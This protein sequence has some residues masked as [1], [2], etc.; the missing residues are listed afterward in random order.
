MTFPAPTV[1]CD[2]SGQW[3]TG[4]TSL[5]GLFPC[6][7]LIVVDPRLVP[8][9]HPAEETFFSHVPVPIQ[10]NGADVSL[11]VL[12]LL[13]ELFWNQFRADLL[14]SEVSNCV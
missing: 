14:A 12:V 10:Q 1:L 5:H 6:L 3:E 8:S 9:Y 7:G 13:G 4:N 2:N 11:S